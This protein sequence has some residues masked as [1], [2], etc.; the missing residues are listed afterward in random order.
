MKNIINLFQRNEK[1]QN[2]AI[3]LLDEIIA[4]GW[5]LLVPILFYFF[6]IVTS[7]GIFSFLYMKY[8][9]EK[10]TS[11]VIVMIF[12]TLGIPLDQDLFRSFF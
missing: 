4:I 3:I 8:N 10:W 1:I 7:V 12:L 9:H 6:G 11:I 5:V 2:L